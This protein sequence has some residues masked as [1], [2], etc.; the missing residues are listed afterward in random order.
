M[1][2]SILTPLLVDKNCLKWILRMLFDAV[3][4]QKELICQKGVVLNLNE[5]HPLKPS[6]V[7]ILALD[8]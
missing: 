3:K 6:N 7:N 2:K 1:R 5:A 4:K 8:P